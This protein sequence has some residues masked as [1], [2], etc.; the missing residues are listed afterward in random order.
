[1]NAVPPE[2]RHS[3]RLQYREARSG[4]L[5]FLSTIRPID[6]ETEAG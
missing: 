5:L 2:N 3:A 4:S 6:K 1:M